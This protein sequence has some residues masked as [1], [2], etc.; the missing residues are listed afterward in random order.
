MCR[1]NQPANKKEPKKVNQD[2][3][4]RGPKGNTTKRRKPT[5]KHN[6]K[7]SLY[8]K[9]LHQHQ[10][11]QAYVIEGERERVPAKNSPAVLFVPRSDL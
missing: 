8:L 1:V 10:E 6:L 9:F 5:K 2:S 4:R 3:V 11:M 7:K